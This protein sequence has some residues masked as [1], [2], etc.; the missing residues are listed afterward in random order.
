MHKRKKSCFFAKNNSLSRSYV[1]SAK[2][3]VFCRLKII[4]TS[5]VWG[6]YAMLKRSLL[7]ILAFLGFVPVV[8]AAADFSD[9]AVG[10]SKASSE[11][12]NFLWEVANV[13]PS[14]ADK[15][16]VIISSETTFSHRDAACRAFSDECQKKR[17]FT[18]LFTVSK[19]PEESFFVRVTFGAPIE[20]ALQEK[21]T[22]MVVGLTKESTLSA[23][24]VLQ[25]ACARSFP[26][27]KMI[28][29]V[30]ATAVVAGCCVIVGRRAV[31]PPVPP[32]LDPA[33]SRR[34]FAAELTRQLRRAF[35]GS[36]TDSSRVISSFEFSWGGIENAIK[37]ADDLSP[38][39]LVLSSESLR[40]DLEKLTPGPRALSPLSM[41][42]Q[43][44]KQLRDN[45]WLIIQV[46]DDINDTE[47]LRGKGEV[48]WR[49]YTRLFSDPDHGSD[50]SSLQ[51]LPFLRVP[52]ELIQGT[53]P[54]GARYSSIE[55]SMDG[56]YRIEASLRQGLLEPFKLRFTDVGRYLQM[57]LIDRMVRVAQAFSGVHGGVRNVL[58]PVSTQR[59]LRRGS[60]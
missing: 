26:V 54:Q 25:K 11:E 50:Y 30:A 5:N 49:A 56:S 7:I 35:S 14:S 36:A 21:P 59:T 31:A 8:G 58:Q 38:K 44:Q 42:I 20:G 24:D 48:V 1:F 15:T 57:V 39:V 34:D 33:M 40:E 28:A 4:T 51:V 22:I 29:G 16:F 18:A 41:L 52:R 9:H 45:N 6:N 46:V 43:Y 47:F 37:R 32:V 3:L 23:R 60:F 53:F 10:A 2:S 55:N 13:L 19:Y 27:G 17:P 12:I